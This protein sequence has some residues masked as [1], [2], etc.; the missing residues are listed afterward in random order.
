MFAFRGFSER[1]YTKVSNLTFELS[2]TDMSDMFGINIQQP[3]SLKCR[4]QLVVHLCRL[5]SPKEV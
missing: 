5:Q 3:I 1:D 2:N 4:L